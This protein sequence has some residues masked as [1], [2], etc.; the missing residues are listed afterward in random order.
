MIERVLSHGFAAAAVDRRGAGGGGARG[1]SVYFRECSMTIAKLRRC[2]PSTPL[3]FV[4][5][6]S[7][8]YLFFKQT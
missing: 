8:L 3:R 6:L 1:R 4:T 7:T 2:V 5:I